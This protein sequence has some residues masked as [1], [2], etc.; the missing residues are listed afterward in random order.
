MSN[1]G[2]NL[3]LKEQMRDEQVEKRKEGVAHKQTWGGGQT[4]V[5]WLQEEQPS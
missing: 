2:F 4:S 1:V 3:Q 5:F